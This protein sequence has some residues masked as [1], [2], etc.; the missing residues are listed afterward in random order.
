MASVKNFQL[1]VSDPMSNYPTNPSAAQEMLLQHDAEAEFIL[2]LGKVRHSIPDVI[3][4]SKFLPY[5][6][7]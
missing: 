1:L 7:Y 6:D 4:F 5:V 2:Q 3:C